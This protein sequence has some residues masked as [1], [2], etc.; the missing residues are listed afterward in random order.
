MWP[1]VV[2]CACPAWSLRKQMRR[3]IWGNLFAFPLRKRKRNKISR[4]SFV[5]VSVRMVNPFHC[6]SWLLSSDCFLC[7]FV[8]FF[9]FFCGSFV[10]LV[11]WC[12]VCY[13]CVWSTFPFAAV[14][15]L[16]V[17]LQSNLSSEI[18]GLTPFPNCHVSLFFFCVASAQGT[19]HPKLSTRRKFLRG[20]CCHL[21]LI[22]SCFW[23]LLF[24]LFFVFHV[25]VENVACV[26][27]VRAVCLVGVAEVL[28]TKLVIVSVLGLK[29]SYIGWVFVALFV[30]SRGD[31]TTSML[32][33][34]TA[35]RA[36]TTENNRHKQ[37]KAI[38]WFLLWAGQQLVREPP[39]DKNGN[40]KFCRGQKSR[41]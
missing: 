33:F 4:F 39:V 3:K 24:W 7:I 25:L 18:V 26:A 16:W 9:V 1:A 14:S 32:A 22:L 19:F 31:T 13:H 12:H 20:W 29:S 2:A 6:F 38:F 5:I 30:V 23:L 17:Q 41:G 34:Y 27:G 37:E 8:I 28:V 11:S 15:V 35:I 10:F 40:S 21:N 36:K